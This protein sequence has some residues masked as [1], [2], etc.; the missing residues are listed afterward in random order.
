VDDL[1]TATKLL[2]DHQLGTGDPSAADRSWAD[3][4]DHVTGVLRGELRSCYAAWLLPHDPDRAAGEVGVAADE[5]TGESELS[6]LLI[7]RA[8]LAVRDVAGDIPSSSGGL[9]EWATSPLPDDDLAFANAWLSVRTGSEVAEL[10]HEYPAALASATLRPSLR[11]LAILYP[12]RPYLASLDETV[13]RLERLGTAVV[14]SSF[15]VVLRTEELINSWLAASSWAE[16]LA[17][18]D[19]HRD[20]LVND[21]IIEL[22]QNSDDANWRRHGA[23]INLLAQGIDGA[24]LHAVVTQPDEAV[25]VALDALESGEFDRIVQLEYASSGFLSTTDAGHL[26]IAVIA[27][28]RGVRDDLDEQARFATPA[29]G[30]AAHRAHVI[31]LRKLLDNAAVELDSDTRDKLGR[32][33]TLLSELGPVER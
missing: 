5:V 30:I 19:D 33:A 18:L 27:I 25:R 2:A 13:G 4:L 24:T 31:H 17:F 6:A 22:L 23:M 3:S 32:F 14:T 28:V 9:P 7:S 15:D 10:L 16:S 12:D 20:E 21:A 8:R 11:I 26:L 1:A 29:T